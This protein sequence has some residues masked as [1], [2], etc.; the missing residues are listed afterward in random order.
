MSK[1][2][3][4]TSV[5]KCVVPHYK[6]DTGE[7]G[8]F[9]ANWNMNS[10]FEQEHDRYVKK[11]HKMSSAIAGLCEADLFSQY[12]LV[13][14][15][16]YVKTLFS[17]MSCYKGKDTVVSFLEAGRPYKLLSPNVDQPNCPDNVVFRKYCLIIPRGELMW[18]LLAIPGDKIG[19]SNDSNSFKIYIHSVKD[20]VRVSAVAVSSDE[21]KSHAA[22][23]NFTKVE[24]KADA[25][26]KP[27]AYYVTLNPFIYTRIR[28]YRCIPPEGRTLDEQHFMVHKMNAFYTHSIGAL[29]LISVSAKRLLQYPPATREQLC[30]D[31]DLLNVGIPESFFKTPAAE[32][33]EVGGEGQAG[34]QKLKWAHFEAGAVSDINNSG[35]EYEGSLPKNMIVFPESKDSDVCRSNRKDLHSFIQHYEHS[36]MVKVREEY[37]EVKPDYAVLDCYDEEEKP[38]WYKLI[39]NTY[40]TKLTFNNEV[41]S[42]FTPNC[43]LTPLGVVA[44]RDI[45]EGDPLIFE[46]NVMPIDK[47]DINK[48]S[49]PWECSIETLNMPDYRRISDFEKAG[50]PLNPPPK[51]QANPMSY[52]SAFVTSIGTNITILPKQN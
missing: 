1:S 20:G 7:S 22:H 31:T 34:T 47:I 51:V 19:V 45:C 13:T 36:I 18:A 4:T 8:Q 11:G 38:F 5:T 39:K 44:I 28:A 49:S 35:F 12:G 16:E 9:F 6:N 33:A 23:L 15:D 24:K 30:I 26:S 40:P 27:D 21:F 17:T 14:H 52:T 42:H 43:M 37:G 29:A 41:I 48:Y 46:E 50:E 10:V 25:A 3:Y 2:I 32:S